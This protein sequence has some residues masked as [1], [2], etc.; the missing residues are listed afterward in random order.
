VIELG[1]YVAVVAAV[2]VIGIRLGMMLAG[3]IDRRSAPPDAAAPS[4]TH[5]EQ[6]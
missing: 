3:R 5:E 1:A 4:A 6:L 2:L